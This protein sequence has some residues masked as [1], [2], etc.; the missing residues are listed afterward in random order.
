[1]SEKILQIIPASGWYAKFSNSNDGEDGLFP[2]ACWAL[3]Q[4][5]DGET[6]VA[7]IDATPDGTTTFVEDAEN[8]EGY[9]F[10]IF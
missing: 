10:K 1:M 6:Y 5:E 8:F 2:L 7:G 9:I 3:C 4:N